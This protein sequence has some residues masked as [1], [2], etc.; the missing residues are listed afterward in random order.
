MALQRLKEAAEKAKIELSTR[1]AD[2]RQPAVHHGGR[3]RAEAPG[4]DAHRGPSW[5]SSSATSSSSTLGRVEQALEDAGM[6]PSEIDEVVLVGG[7]TRMPLVQQTVKQFFGKE[8][9]KGVNPDEVVAH[10]RRHPGG[11]AQGRSQ[12]RPA[13]RRDA[14]VRWVSRRWA[15]S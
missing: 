14:A 7:Q 11:R 8:P 10:R 2:G 3:E 6:Q 9:H 1:H 5:S 4:H 12:G 13:A 15:A